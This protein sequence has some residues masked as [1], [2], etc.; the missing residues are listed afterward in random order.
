MDGDWNAQRIAGLFYN[1]VNE[2]IIAV[3]FAI[4]E[5]NLQHRAAVEAGDNSHLAAVTVGEVI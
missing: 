1:A 4:R 5:S 2:E 3:V